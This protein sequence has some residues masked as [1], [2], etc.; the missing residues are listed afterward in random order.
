MKVYVV[1]SELVNTEE[2]ETE[3][4]NRVVEVVDSEEKARKTLEELYQGITDLYE[5]N[6]FA[7]SDEE[8]DFENGFG[9]TIYREDMQEEITYCVYV[10]EV[11]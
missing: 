8:F 4:K 11:K 1:T 6:E 10:M 2:I 3:I 9:V 5:E 7:Y